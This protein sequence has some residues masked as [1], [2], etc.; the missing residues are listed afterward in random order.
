MTNKLPWEKPNTL[1]RKSSHLA[2]VAQGFLKQDNEEKALEILTDMPVNMCSESLYN[3][4]IKKIYEDEGDKEKTL[5]IMDSFSERSYCSRVNYSSLA[6]DYYKE[7][8]REK[9]LEVIEK[10][11][12][13]KHKELF[14]YKYA[15][16][17]E[18][19]GDQEKA[20]E[21]IEMIEGESTLKKAFYANRL[22]TEV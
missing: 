15:K 21:I 3:S 1:S 10:S 13:Y 5:E 14:Y 4:I 17:C 19:E 22:K 2:E 11:N 18:K 20:L 16:D 9:A 8:N 7:G 6:K 12:D